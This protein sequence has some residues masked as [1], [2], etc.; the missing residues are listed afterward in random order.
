MSSLTHKNRFQNIHFSVGKVPLFLFVIV[1]V[2][3]ITAC[4]DVIELNLEEA[5]PQLV[6]DAWLNNQPGPQRI[7]LDLS[8]SYFN[9]SVSQGLRDAQVK[10]VRNDT[11]I[12]T[13]SHEGE[14]IYQWEPVADEIIGVPGDIFTLEIDWNGLS[15]RGVT[16]MNRVPLVDSI[17][18]EYRENEI[19]LDDG[20]Y[21]QFYARDFAG[22]GDTYWIKTY[23]NG[24]YLD[25]S[26][27]LNIAYDAGFD[28]GTGI[29]GIIFIPPIRE[30]INELDEDLLS[31]PY[32]AGDS[33]RVEI[34]ALTIEAFNFMEIA[35]DQINNGDNGIFALP[36]ANTRS[37]VMTENG[38][39]ALGF[40]NVAAVSSLSRVVE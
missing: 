8:Q 19:F 28:A 20:I 25:K 32:E 18:L 6:V 30:F 21:G 17:G 9:Q 13:F 26:Q 3:F 38:E 23:K 7:R 16:M 5:E 10:V 37:N 39:R 24:K 2:I 22:K 29:D 15:Y 36:L 1:A 31:I 4:E 27:E 12:L 14:G 33:I 40:F 34:H 11:D 35:R